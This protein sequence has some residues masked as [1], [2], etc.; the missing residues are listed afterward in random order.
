MQEP[1]VRT[2]R[3]AI[4]SGLAAAI[5]VGAA[6]FMIGR[7]SVSPPPAPPAPPPQPVAPPP[8][9]PVEPP[10]P[11]LARADLIQ[12]ADAAA[13]ATASGTPPPAALGD[14]VGRRFTL[15]LPFGCSGPAGA[16][17][18]TLYRW[19][20]D[21]A[22]SALRIRAA[23][24]NWQGADW[25]PGATPPELEAIEGFWVSYPWASGETCPAVDAAAVP[26]GA[27]PVTLPGQTLALAQFFPAGTSRQAFRGGAP[28]ETVL[29]IAPKDLRV[30]RG[31]R[32]RLTGKIER[33]PGGGPVRCI[34]PAGIEQRPI[35]VV[36][37]SFDEL[38][39]ENPATTKT[40]ATWTFGHGRA[41]GS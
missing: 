25:W 8:A 39:I 29:R 4:A 27:D 10:P 9:E 40:L 17:S 19:R 11:M 35:C 3:L 1:S 34:Q 33:V 21:A 41:T 38:A 22:R 28:F 31:F 20:Y 18:P 26:A 37:V 12:L 30:D 24:A 32:L 7:A 16:D 2:S 23:S 14:A 13:D 5:V 36:A 15:Y 6:G